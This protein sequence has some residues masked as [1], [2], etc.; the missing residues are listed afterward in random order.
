M[1]HDVVPWPLPVPIAAVP[2]LH[3]TQQLHRLLKHL[4]LHQVKMARGDEPR[5][6]PDVVARS[7]VVSRLFLL[8]SVV[9]KV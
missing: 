4:F 6:I 3:V 1:V 9:A 2:P 5:C 7:K 8:H